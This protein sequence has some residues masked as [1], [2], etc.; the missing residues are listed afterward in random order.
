MGRYDDMLDMPR[1]TSKRHPRMSNAN[2]AKQFMPFAALRGYGDALAEREIR[3]ESRAMLSDEDIAALDEALRELAKA[4]GQ[5]EH[6]R[7]TLEVFEPKAGGD[8]GAGRYHTLTGRLEKLPEGRGELR[9]DER[10]FSLGDI[11][12][13]WPE[14]EG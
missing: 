2:R 3:Y 4:L 14:E 9:M 10:T 13:L 12:N 5:G 8:G 6:P 11:V 7:I 1:P